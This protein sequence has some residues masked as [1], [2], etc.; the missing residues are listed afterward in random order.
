MD[1]NHLQ[2]HH[3]DHHLQDYCSKSLSECKNREV[4][5]REGGK[6]T[7]AIMSLRLF[8]KKTVTGIISCKL[9]GKIGRVDEDQ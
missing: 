5:E 1:E 6:M 2:D 7:G 9:N 4:R 8:L 3:K